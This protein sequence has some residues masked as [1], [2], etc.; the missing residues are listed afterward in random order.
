M[1][2][3]I[4]FSSK[5]LRTI[6]LARAWEALITVAESSTLLSVPSVEA[7]TLIFSVPLFTVVPVKNSGYSD[8]KSST[9]ACA[10]QRL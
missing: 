1:R 6:S 3:F 9:L 8:S 7:V 10:P 5:L 4:N 2:V